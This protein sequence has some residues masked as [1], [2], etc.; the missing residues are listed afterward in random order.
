MHIK[1]SCYI[2]QYKNKKHETVVVLTHEL[3]TTDPFSCRH[4]QANT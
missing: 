3:S 4:P 2:Y 1:I